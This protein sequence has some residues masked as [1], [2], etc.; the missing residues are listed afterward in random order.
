M[1]ALAV[2]VT[3]AG[4]AAYLLL[5]PWQTGD[6]PLPARDAGPEQVVSVYLDALNEHDCG[7][8]EALMVEGAEGS[9]RAWCESVATLEDVEIRGHFIEPPENS[10][11]SAPDE[12][13]NVPVSFDPEWRAFHDDGSLEEGAITWTYLLVRS[14]PDA[15]WRIFDQGVG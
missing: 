7:T 3:V 9:A 14:S 11:H 1:I 13:A 6:V 5:P 10:G 2:A 15:P 8:A 4:L 12:V